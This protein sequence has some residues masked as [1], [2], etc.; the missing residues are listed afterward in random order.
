MSMFLSFSNP[1]HKTKTTLLQKKWQTPNSNPL[2]PIKPSSQ[3]TA[4]IKLL[5]C[6]PQRT[7]FAEPNQHVLNFLHPILICRIT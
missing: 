4:G 3:L 5:L 6:Q 7:T 2:E 1:T